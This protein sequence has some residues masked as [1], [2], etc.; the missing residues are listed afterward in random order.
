MLL[1]DWILLQYNWYPYKKG[2]FGHRETH[3]EGRH[4][5]DR[6]KMPHNWS[7][8]SPSQ[9]TP[10]VPGKCQKLRQPGGFCSGTFAEGTALPTLRFQSRSLQNFLQTQFSYCMPHDLWC[11]AGAAPETNTPAHSAVVRCGNTT[12]CLGSSQFPMSFPH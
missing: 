1:L 8:T 6:E 9:G 12:A 3:T 10:R 2:K 5:E 7:G 11:F 4:C